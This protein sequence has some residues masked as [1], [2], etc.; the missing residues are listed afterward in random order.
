MKKVLLFVLAVGLVLFTGCKS[1]KTAQKIGNGSQDVWQTMLVKQMDCQIQDG[2]LKVNYDNG[3]E[4]YYKILDNNGNVSFTWDRSGGRKTHDE[5]VSSYSG[6]IDIPSFITSGENDEFVFNVVEVD[7]NAFWGCDKVTRISLPYSIL[8]IRMGAFHGCS[9][10][11]EIY[12]NSANQSYTDIDGVLFSKDNK[13]LIT[14]PAKREAAEYEVPQGVSF[15]CPEAF[16]GCDKLRKISLTSDVTAISDYAF[17]DCTSLE[18]LRLGTSVR[19]IGKEACKNCPKLAFIH[20]PGFFPPHNCPTVYD[21]ETKETCKVVVP[22]GQKGAYMMNLE[23]NEFKN[24]Q[25]EW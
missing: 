20:S 25:E 5:G 15:I 6:R 24:I 17:Q 14:Y 13:M 9:A 16:L 18:E 1:S 22:K 4:L 21:K 8:R 2:I 3:S 23:W 7:E 12:V 19:I 10:L 11:T